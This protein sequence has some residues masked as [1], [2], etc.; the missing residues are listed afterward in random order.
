MHV[1][2]VDAAADMASVLLEA[3]EAAEGEAPR[4]AAHAVTV[5]CDVGAEVLAAEAF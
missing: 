3:V 2:A 4:P 1:P 5:C